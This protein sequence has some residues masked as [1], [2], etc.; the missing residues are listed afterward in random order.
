[1]ITKETGKHIHYIPDAEQIK[2]ASSSNQATNMN[3]SPFKRGILKY[4]KRLIKEKEP[5][6]SA[7]RINQNPQQPSHNSP[8]AHSGTKSICNSTNYNTGG[9]PSTEGTS[10]LPSSHTNT[11][12]YNSNPAHPKIKLLHT[13]Q[14]NPQNVISALTAEGIP[15]IDNDEDHFKHKEQRDYFPNDINIKSYHIH[16]NSHSSN[17]ANPTNVVNTHNPYAYAMNKSN[18]PQ[19]HNLNQLKQHVFTTNSSYYDLQNA[20]NPR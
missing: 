14:V 4:Y 5:G 16:A 1:M 19:A 6:N 9:L 13:N 12:T 17:A 11:L 2:G 3:S 7:Q 18:N 10:S 20:Q 15:H 8:H